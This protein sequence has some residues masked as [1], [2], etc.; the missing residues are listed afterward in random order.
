MR[1]L[2]LTQILPYPPNAGPRVKTWNVLRYLVRGGHEIHLTSFIRT[3]EREFLGPIRDLCASVNTV[4]IRRSRPADLRAWLRSHASGK[5]FLVE[6]DDLK[7]LRLLVQKIVADREIEAIHADQLTIAQFALE[8]RG[9]SGANGPN[10]KLVFD[11]HNAVWTIVERMRQHMPTLLG[12]VFDLES[13]RVWDYEGQIVRAFD[14]IL[15]VSELDR[16]SLIQAGVSRLN[17]NGALVDDQGIG[18]RITVVPIG[19]DTESLIPVPRPGDSSNILTIG[20]LLYPPNADGVRWFAKEVFPLIRAIA[21]EFRLTIVGKNPPGD[22][23]GME[24]RGSTAIKVTGYVPDLTPFLEAAA[25]MVVPVKA[26]GGMRVRILE[27]F[28]RGMPMVTTAV[29]LE[30]IEAEHDR[31]ILI[32]NSVEKFADAVVR[33]LRDEGKRE[34]LSNNGRKLVVEK[35]EWRTALAPLDE[36]YAD[37]LTEAHAA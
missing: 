1:I 14:R 34:E 24:R 7:A 16:A 3:D 12:P 31:D 25:V 33:L 6:R 20:T 11:A 5:P 9:L 30:G 26:G 13:R 37:S 36:I 2:F 19:V 27:G 29:G 8:V 4:S 23:R 22:I 28:A 21:P 35:Y 18:H 32:A 10:P 17:G 15:T